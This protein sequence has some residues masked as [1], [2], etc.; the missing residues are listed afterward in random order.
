MILR[1]RK[2]ITLKNSKHPL[3]PKTNI[4]AYI[5]GSHGDQ[6]GECEIK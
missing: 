4:Q 5:F 6:H 1:S 3:P 2:E